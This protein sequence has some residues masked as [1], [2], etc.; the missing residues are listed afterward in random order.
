MWLAEQEWSCV[1]SVKQDGKLSEQWCP[2]GLLP[3]RSKIM[4]SRDKWLGPLGAP[5]GVFPDAHAYQISLT[6]FVRPALQTIKVDEHTAVWLV[7]LREDVLMGDSWLIRLVHQGDEVSTACTVEMFEPVPETFDPAT[8]K[9]VID[10]AS[11]PLGELV[12]AGALSQEVVESA[13]NI[14]LSSGPAMPIEP[15]LKSLD[16][17][18]VAA[19]SLP[20]SLEACFLLGRLATLL[21]QVPGAAFLGLCDEAVR[22]HRINLRRV[23]RAHPLLWAFSIRGALLALAEVTPA[24]DLPPLIN[25]CRAAIGKVDLSPVEQATLHYCEGELLL[26]N[27]KQASYK[28]AVQ[29]FSQSA[30]AARELGA[31]G[32]SHLF[33]AL[34]GLA[35]AH[36]ALGQKQ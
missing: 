23:N 9:L 31:D 16:E 24:D 6:S 12:P 1:H 19:E 29:A 21:A 17:V 35:R 33:Q 30:E 34:D 8:L 10:L 20:P 22:L 28:E 26:R 7:A 18:I 2:K 15:W 3:S 11:A 36:R 27:Q 25:A 14:A 4:L 5:P 32:G 13:I